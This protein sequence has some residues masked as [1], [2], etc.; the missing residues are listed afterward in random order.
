MSLRSYSIVSGFFIQD[1]LD[2]DPALIGAVPPRFGLIDGSD[3]RWSNLSQKIQRMNEAD[4]QTSYKLFILGRHGEGFHNVGEAKYGTKAWDDYWSKLNGD[5]ELIWGPDPKLTSLGEEQARIVNQEWRNES[6]YGLSVP[7]SRYCSPL[8]RATKT[9]LLTFDGLP[10]SA[11]HPVVI[12][13]N[14]REEYGEHTCDKRNTRTW[15]STYFPEFVFEED[16]TEGDELW[17]ANERETHLQV[18]IRAQSVLDMIFNTDD[19]DV[20]S[21]T[22][23]GGI[24]NGFLTAM[25]RK[26][27]ALPTGG[28]LPVVVKSTLQ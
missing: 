24:I 22:A 9:C 8:T 23:H 26:R 1:H 11:N 5:G 6:K 19:N 15:V 16:F 12:V 18:T 14:C 10:T 17:T 2:A 4:D 7:P 25:G 28:V 3:D 27:Y 20:I 21:I 13:E